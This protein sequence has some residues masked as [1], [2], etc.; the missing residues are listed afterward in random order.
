MQVQTR[1]LSSE[2]RKSRLVVFDNL[3][4]TRTSNSLVESYVTADKISGRE[5]Y[6]G[7]GTRPNII[8]WTI[9]ANQPSLSKDFVGRAY[10]IR[11][12]PPVYSPKWNARVDRLIEE[13]R[14]AIYGD[15]VGALRAEPLADLE[16]GEWSRW[17][18][19]E[20]EVLCHVCDPRPLFQVVGERRK[21]LD[22]DDSTVH[23]VHETLVEFIKKRFV[24]LDPHQLHLSIPSG[25]VGEC[26]ARL[27]PSGNNTISIG[28]WLSSMVIPNFSKKRTKESREWVWKGDD[29]L[30]EKPMDWN[31]RPDVPSM[32]SVIPD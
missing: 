1:I 3:K 30:L 27:C 10:P 4:G 15:I 12:I 8:T 9:T 20:S 17:P 23:T 11:I 32:S 14:W 16:D 6:V 18:E 28:R 26:F 2:G 7:E 19:W 25:A 22:D 13:N 5:L 31:S 21:D 29:A 24:D